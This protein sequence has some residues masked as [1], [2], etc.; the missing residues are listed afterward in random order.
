MS[1]RLAPRFSPESEKKAWDDFV[2]SA[3]AV[4][5]A[6]LFVVLLTTISHLRL[7][8]PWPHLLYL[9]VWR[10]PQA[11][12]LAVL[13]SAQPWLSPLGVMLAVSFLPFGLHVLAILSVLPLLKTWQR[14][15]YWL[16]LGC[17]LIPVFGP[18]AS[19]MIMQSLGDL[20]D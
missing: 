10:Q 5:A 15:A 6:S 1:P 4:L 9:S 16:Y 12:M 14:K 7:H 3:W 20:V 11:A 2:T 19:L 18:I 13:W 8:T 17:A